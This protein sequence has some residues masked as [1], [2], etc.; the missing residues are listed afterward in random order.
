MKSVC[1]SL[2]MEWN[3]IRLGSLAHGIVTKTVHKTL[4][5]GYRVYG[6]AGSVGVCLC[7]C[8]T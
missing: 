3:L 8:L 5:E 2:S 4:P 7:N 1:I 6:V